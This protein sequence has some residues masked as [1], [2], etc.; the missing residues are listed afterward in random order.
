MKTMGGSNDKDN[1][2]SLYAREHFLAH[3]ILMHIYAGTE[4]EYKT[5]YAFWKMCYCH[6]D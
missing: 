3:K 5:T 2:I 4:Y 6:K 1:L